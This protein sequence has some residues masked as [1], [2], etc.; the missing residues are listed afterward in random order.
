[1]LIDTAV[2]H[3]RPREKVYRISDRSKTGL[4]L[5]IAPEGGKR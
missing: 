1:M 3:A 2:K 5:E 4:C